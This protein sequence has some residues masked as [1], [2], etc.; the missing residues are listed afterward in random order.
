MS[1]QPIDLL[2]NNST[3]TTTKL[4][5]QLLSS[6]SDS[7][8]RVSKTIV[9]LRAA[10]MG[11]KKARTVLQGY[12]MHHEAAKEP[13]AMREY[14]YDV[15]CWKGH[16]KAAMKVKRMCFWAAVRHK[17]KSGRH[18]ISPIPASGNTRTHSNRERC[19]GLKGNKLWS[20]PDTSWTH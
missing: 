1:E 18:V 16:E 10:L 6:A 19:V 7:C 17:E 20:A 3:T 14:A 12:V 2:M 8:A 15:R 4:S 13:Y 11:E 9:G 5:E